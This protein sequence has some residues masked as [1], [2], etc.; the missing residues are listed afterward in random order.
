MGL[1]KNILFPWSYDKILRSHPLNE[2][3]KELIAEADQEIL[4]IGIGTGQNLPYYKDSVKEIHAIDPNPGMHQ[5]LKKKLD[6][7]SI[8]VK[9][10]HA[11]CENLPYPDH[12]FDTVVA[13]LV[14]CSVKNIEKSLQ[15]IH[16]V[17]K[18]G[19]KFL[20]L[21]H[22][23]SNEQNLQKW[24]QRI[25]PYWKYVGDGCRLDINIEEKIQKSPLQIIQLTKE[26]LEDAPRIIGY[27]YKGKALK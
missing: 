2:K 4:E 24:Q 9:F 26:Y 16:R 12:Y 25:T 17:L 22:G 11:F 8:K 20:F 5:Q 7:F 27:L 10:Q 1:Y 3:R 21:E 18:P 14:L 15:E 13:T 23:L 19:G 6:I